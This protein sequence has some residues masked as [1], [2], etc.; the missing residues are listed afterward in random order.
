LTQ[1]LHQRVLAFLQKVQG[2]AFK[3]KELARN[4]DLPKQGAE[5][6]QL[7]SVLRELQEQN[8]IERLKGSRWMVRP[9]VDE[10]ESVQE[11][12]LTVGTLRQTGKLSYVKS[13]ERDIEGDIMISQRK[14]GEAR[15]GDK[16][17][18]RLLFDTHRHLGL[19]G[20]IVEVL[21]RTGRASVEM[22]AIARRYG[23]SMEFPEDVDAEAN[24]LA[25]SIPQSETRSRLDLRDEECFTIDPE[26]ARD[27]DDAVSLRMDTEGNFVLGVHIADVSHYVRE[28]S[29]LDQEALRRGTSVYMVEGVFPMLPERLSN[30]LCSLNEGQDRLTYSV[31]LTISPRGA[32]R[33][34][35]IAKTVI[36]SRKRFTYEEVQAILD[37]GDGPHDETLGRMKALAGILMKKRFREGSVDFAVPEVKYILDATGYPVDIVPKKRLMSMRM[38]EEFML[39]A[40]KTVA[41]AA[42]KLRGEGK[43]FIYRVHDLP[44]SEKVRELMEFLLHLGVKVQLDHSSSKSFQDM[45]EVVRGRAEEDVVQDVTIRSMA[46]AVYSAENIGHFGLGFKH[47][48]HF[49]SPIRRYPD[50]IVHRLLFQYFGSG[51]GARLSEKRLGDIARLSSIRERLAVEAERASRKIKQVEYMKRHVGDEFD[52]LISGVTRY[53][54]YVEIMPSLVEGLVHVRSLDDYFEFDKARWQLVG[55]RSRRVYRLGDKVR[56]RVARVDSVD[57]EIDF[58]LLDDDAGGLRSGTDLS[59]GTAD[60]T[61]AVR[62]HNP[63]VSGGKRS[64]S[65]SGGGTDRSAGSSRGSSGKSGSGRTRKSG[66]GRSGGGTSTSGG[67]RGSGST[68]SGGSSTRKRPSGGSRGRGKKR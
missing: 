20:E 57:Q 28:G 48:T 11:E 43:S 56:V 62:P 59:S 3:T 36:H 18:V 58:V 55:Q 21:G 49:T 24:A 25:A 22:L 14:L 51:Q 7:K 29:A 16:V 26:D 12:R 37:G 60:G 8:A 13:D 47:Y 50:L 23:L 32:V 9:T 27:F 6:Q 1:T 67:T 65:R 10:A 46:K 40:N 5:Y 31:I 53:G 19:E 34:F 2:Q 52:A 42:A 64:T 39:L 15:D 17:V 4:L 44:D 66:S 33:D 35:Q 45:L 30:H 38:I 61:S 63:R 68:R 54:L 41:L